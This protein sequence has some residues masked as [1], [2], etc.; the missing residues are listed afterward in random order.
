MEAALE[1]TPLTDETKPLIM[2]A[3]NDRYKQ[4]LRVCAKHFVGT[5]IASAQIVG[6]SETQLLLRHWDARSQWAENSI[7][8]QNAQ[9]EAVTAANAGAVRRIFLDMARSA[10]EA[11]GEDLGLPK[12]DLMSGQESD[13]GPGSYLL[14]DL[15]DSKTLECLN[16]DDSYPV[17]GAISGESGLR[18]DP[19]VDHQLLIKLG[20]QQP[21]KLKAI[22]FHG[23]SG[24]ETAPKVVK[25]FQGHMDMDFQEA[26]EQ[27]AVQTLDLL[28]S[29]V[30]AGDPITLRFVKFQH[31][32]TLQLFVQENFGADVTSIAHIQFWGTVAETVDMKAWKPAVD[33]MAN[34]VAPIREPAHEDPSGV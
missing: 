19:D 2:T 10:A 32:S 20:F 4:A 30:D 9:G 17:S 24:D 15:V 33:S 5:D 26:D 6:L 11:T 23:T 34:P 12:A 7:A 3:M 13:K 25:I 14:N 31:V 21:I 16:Q 27:E 29:Q 8:Y 1:H 28:E 18:S 22:S